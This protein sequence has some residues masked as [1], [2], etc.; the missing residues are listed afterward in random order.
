VV[1]ERDSWTCHLCSQRVDASLSGLDPD[2]P[3]IDHVT[4][5]SRGGEHSYANT[6]CAH[7]RCNLR[8]GN[9]LHEL[10]A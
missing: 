1:F 8:K 5:L 7:R 4:P 3:T 6:A 10:V 9:R 2:G